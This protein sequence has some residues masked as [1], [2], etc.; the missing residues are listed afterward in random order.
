[1]VPEP[2]IQAIDVLNKLMGTVRVRDR[3]RDRVRVSSSSPS[4]NPNVFSVSGAGLRHEARKVL[5]EAGG[6]APG[7][8]CLSDDEQLVVGTA[9]ARYFCPASP[10][11]S[12]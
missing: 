3:D 5:A 11:P 6:A 7:C 8:S 12:P 9:Q 10:S 4:P 1:M 2:A